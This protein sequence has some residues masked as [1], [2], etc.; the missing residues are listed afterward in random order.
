M[1]SPYEDLELQFISNTELRADEC[2]SVYNNSYDFTVCRVLPS[3]LYA[4]SGYRSNSR[5]AGL[6]VSGELNSLGLFL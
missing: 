2:L 5:T 4:K 6:V 3:C 1:K